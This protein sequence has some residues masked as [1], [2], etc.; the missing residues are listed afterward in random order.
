MAKKQ[1]T[2]EQPTQRPPERPRRAVIVLSDGVDTTSR[3]T[4]EAAKRAAEGAEVTLFSLLSTND[5]ERD[6]NP[7]GDAVLRSLSEPTGGDLLNARS[8]DALLGS[9]SR[10]ETLRNQYA[11]AYEPSAFTPD[12]NYRTI[13][14]APLKRGLKTKR[15][16]G[17]F[18]RGQ[19]TMRHHRTQHNLPQRDEVTQ[20][21]ARVLRL[22]LKSL[23]QQG[24][25]ARDHECCGPYRIE[26]QPGLA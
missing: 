18:A 1:P 9:F 16:R 12:G 10:V 6:R 14:I 24:D 5:P 11:L 3:V 21:V 8:E 2:I 20:L 22:G 26:I 17:Y 15:R 13:A 4:L 23:H 7:Q 25:Y 19:D